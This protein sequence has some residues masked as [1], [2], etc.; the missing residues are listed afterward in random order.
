MT[1]DVVLTATAEADIESAS[2]W[3]AQKAPAESVKHQKRP[4]SEGGW[5]TV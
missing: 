1:Y 4:T 3:I 2:D 5:G